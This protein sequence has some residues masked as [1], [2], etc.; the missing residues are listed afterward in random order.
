MGQGDGVVS[1]FKV[2]TDDVQEV[3]GWVHGLQVALCL[4]VGTLLLLAPA[5]R[6]GRS[7]GFVFEIDPSGD[8]TL[9]IIFLLLGLS[10][11]YAMIRLYKFLMGVTLLLTGLLCW[12]LGVFLLTGALFSPTG[13]LASPFCIYVGG[14][15][16]IQSVL[17]T[18]RPR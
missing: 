12:V 3:L 4:S 11:V 10:M 5:Q 13:V 2:S 8:D 15:M 7:Y 16:L 6:K 1:R 18:K 9:G 17:L 14:H